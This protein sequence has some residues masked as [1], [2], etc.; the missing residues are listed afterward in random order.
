MQSLTFFKEELNDLR[1]TS[2]RRRVQGGVAELV[3]KRFGRTLN[4]FRIRIQTYS[5]KSLQENIYTKVLNL[6]STNKS[7][8]PAQLS[9]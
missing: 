5:I 7:H 9:A 3:L 8:L 2:P 4:C 6:L 1:V